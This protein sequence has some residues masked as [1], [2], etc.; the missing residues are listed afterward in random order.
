MATVQGK[1]A[2]LCIEREKQGTRKKKKGGKKSK[3]D[4]KKRRKKTPQ[5]LS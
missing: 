1:S 4:L 5:T 3:Q 2:A